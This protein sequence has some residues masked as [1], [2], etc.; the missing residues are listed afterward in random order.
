M[1]EHFLLYRILTVPCVN[2]RSSQKF[3][4]SLQD[5]HMSH[6]REST[7]DGLSEKELRFITP[8]ISQASFSMF[9][10]F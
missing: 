9:S 5:G 7:D 2:D 3:L 10:F 1:F 6:N 8:Q 4:L